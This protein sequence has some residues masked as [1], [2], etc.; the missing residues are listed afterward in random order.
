MH[1]CIIQTLTKSK[2]MKKITLLTFLLSTMFAFSQTYTATEDFTGL[3]TAE[4][5]N[6]NGSTIS[7]VESTPVAGTNAVASDGDYGQIITQQASAPW[8]AGTLVF[9][10]NYMDLTTTRTIEVD[11]YSDAATDILAKAVGAIGAGTDG[12]TDASHP[13]GGWATLV[14]DFDVPKDGGAASVDQF[15]KLF[16]FPNWNTTGGDGSGGWDGSCCGENGANDS[17]VSTTRYDNV[18]YVAGDSTDTCSNG[19][20]DGDET[21]VDCG[22][23]CE[24]CPEPVFLE[25][26]GTQT[27]G[28]R[29]N[30]FDLSNNYQFGFGYATEN[31]KS[32]MVADGIIFSPNFLIWDE[33]DATPQ[34][35]NPAW[36]PDWFSSPGVP[37]KRVEANLE[38]Q[39]N[40]LIGKDITFSGTIPAYSLLSTYEIRA[41]VKL[42]PSDYSSLLP[43]SEVLVLDPS[44]TDFT[45]N[46]TRAESLGATNIQYG[47]TVYGDIADPNLEIVLGSV[48]LSSETL[49]VANNELNVFKVY[50]NPTLGDW[51]VKAQNTIQAIQVYDILGKEVFASR[52]NNNEAIISTDG[53]RTGVYFAKVT[54]NNVEKT[55]KLIKQ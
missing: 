39:D 21:G 26:D 1:L 23:S 34:N 14:F 30:A 54:S 16:F 7:T 33:N 3:T 2:N 40:T 6:D 10:D 11:V 49:G 24:T 37:N 47:Y 4:F 55:V 12:A 43:G 28:A 15:E 51:T 19:V 35:G 27:F 29:I 42:F 25:L 41:F 18:K 45:I 22:G 44:D 36:N 46:V 20:Q 8:Q 13:G 17:P 9:Q 52:P 53:M 48:K 31:L 32:E 50:P 38:L 5:T